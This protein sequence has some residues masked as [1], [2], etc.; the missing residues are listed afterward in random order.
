MKLFN[1]FKKLQSLIFV[2]TIVVFSMLFISFDDTDDFDLAKNLDIYQTLIRELRLYY[3]DDIQ[4]AKIIQTSIEQMLKSLDPY[5]VFYPE[6]KIEDFKFMT[7]G[8]YGGI[9]ALIRK[10][11]GNIIIEQVYKNYPAEKA[12][13]RPG[14]IVKKVE[15]KQIDNKNTDDISEMLKG[16]PNT[17]VVLSIY[18]PFTK[19]NLNIT[20]TRQKIQVKNVPYSGMINSETGYIKLTGFTQSAYEEVKQ[21]LVNLKEKNATQIIFDLR[22]NPGGLLNE[23]VKIVG[24]FVDKGTDVVSTRGKMQQWNQTLKTPRQPIDTEMDIVVLV[25]SNSASASEIV[26]GALQDLD[27]AVIVG[28]R[29]YGKGLVQ[30]T[31]DLS[32]N[33]KLKI[34]TAKYYIPSGR[35][36]Q[37]LDYTHR[38]PDGSVGHVP[39]S[40]ISEFKTKNGRTVY[41]GGGILPDIKVELQ[42]IDPL[43][44]YLMKNYIIFDYANNYRFLNDKISTAANY[45]MTDK[46]YSDFINY[47]V[48]R[49]INYET[50]TDKALV[51][52]INTA[53]NE[54]YYDKLSSD[55][56]LL[57][58]DL[59]HNVKDDLILFKD[60][61]KELLNRSIV[62]R[63]YYESGLIQYAI[64]NDPEVKKGL[65]LLSNDTKYKSILMN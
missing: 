55:I 19:E 43:S 12:G 36:I 25:N 15:N 50:E 35:C 59:S 9:G 8:Q 64:N 46:E 18:R 20:I 41:D 57:E 45:T 54:K 5:T 32:Y 24:L 2:G 48:E 28:Q 29:T 6:S 3:V 42:K 38:N 37:A 49:N 4:S 34:T 1:K 60:D 40:I 53:K 17:D 21:A 63:Y 11:S 33:A 7:T 10:D 14:D 61:I 22:G 31:R 16:V 27:R 47:V 26:S 56:K 30:T 62:V 58:A 39:D 51:E 44:K 65:E 23:A 52:L 13:I